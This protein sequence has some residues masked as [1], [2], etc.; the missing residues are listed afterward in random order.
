MTISAPWSVVIG[1]SPARR[2][3][4]APRPPVST[5]PPQHSSHPTP[6][7]PRLPVRRPAAAPRLLG[8]QAPAAEGRLP[9][10]RAE[11][12]RG[13]AASLR[14]PDLQRPAP[15]APPRLRTAPRRDRYG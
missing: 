11:P 10:A 6:F 12:R 9:P 1:P 2:P 4:V 14:S 13:G 8:G 7:V 5:R 3:E 15:P